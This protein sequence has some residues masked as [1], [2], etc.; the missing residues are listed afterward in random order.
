MKLIVTIPAFNEE[1]SLLKQARNYLV[2]KEAIKKL[3]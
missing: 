1:K 2:T 3:Q